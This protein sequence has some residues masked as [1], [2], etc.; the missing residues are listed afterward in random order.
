MNVTKELTSEYKL[1]AQ[2]E[3][4]ANYLFNENG[5]KMVLRINHGSQMH[6]D[7]Q[8]SYE[9]AA[10]K[11]LEGID[12]IPQVVAVD[13]S[14]DALGNG[15]LV[16]TYLPGHH[17]DYNNWEEMKAVAKC[18]ADIHSYKVP[19]NNSLVSPKN[20]LKAILDECE[21]M[22]SVYMKSELPTDE[23]KTRL[24]KLLDKA[25]SLVDVN[26]NDETY[27]CII[28]TELNSTNF[29]ID[30]DYARLVDWEKPL[31]G[32][33]AQDIGHFLA[34]TTTFWKTDVIFDDDTIMG[35]IDEYIKQIGDRFD[36][37]G[38]VARILQ[39]TTITC[40]R[41][42]TWCAMAWV[43]YQKSEKELMNE[44]TRRKLDQ[45]LDNSFVE[46][47]E[48]IVNRAATY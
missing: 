10:M 46:M 1:L 31:Y 33:P 14:A 16:M 23:A 18:L 43:Q 11:Y 24:R 40:L 12:R 2:G 7:N 5:E 3:Y 8:I 26:A 47:I 42:M 48:N 39:F 22:I 25:W 45:Y 36:T 34:P 4:N 44:S 41:G 28:N 37:T 29:L 30:G 13:D 17:L 38:L 15:A 21:E 9:A 35:F 19:E 20:S 32:D 6:L 27:R